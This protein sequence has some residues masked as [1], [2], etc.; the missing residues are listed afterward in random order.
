MALKEQDIVLYSTDGD[1]NKIIQMPV[2][3][4]ENVEGAIKTINGVVPD[5][6]GDVPLSYIPQISGAKFTVS[7]TPTNG[8]AYTYTMTTSAFVEMSCT[9]GVA[10][11][12]QDH[13]GGDN[14]TDWTEVTY[15]GN[16][17]L[18]VLINGLEV[19]PS[20]TV[21]EASQSYSTKFFALK[22][23]TIEIYCK[24]SMSMGSDVPHSFSATIYP[25]A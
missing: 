10:R 25:H 16:S 4:V 5:S 11:Y 14:G 21:N 15:H 13:S 17:T 23:Q 3:R 7:A 22:G 2:T 19:Y 1:G 9:S 20:K 8:S 12:V 6:S 18:S 24:R